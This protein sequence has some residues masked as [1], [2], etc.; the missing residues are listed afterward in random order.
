MSNENFTVM[1]V[2]CGGCV[3]A[4]ENGLK[5]MPGVDSV[6]VTIDGGQVTVTGSDLSREQLSAKLSELGY[7]EA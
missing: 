4:I 1:N 3:S 5:E 7:P 6:E 2:K